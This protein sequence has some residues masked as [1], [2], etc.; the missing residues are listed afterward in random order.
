LLN[1]RFVFRRRVVGVSG[2][3][4]FVFIYAL[5]YIANSVLLWLL[6]DHFGFQP[7][8]AMLI[9]IALSVPMTYLALRSAFTG[10]SK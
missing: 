9:V 3:G 8:I 7:E 4:Q 10:Q 5:Q 6:V 1:S 2:K